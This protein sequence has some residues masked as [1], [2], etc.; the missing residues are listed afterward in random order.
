VEIFSNNDDILLSDKKMEE[1]KIKAIDDGNNYLI[2]IKKY[3]YN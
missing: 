1:S 3:K 2:L